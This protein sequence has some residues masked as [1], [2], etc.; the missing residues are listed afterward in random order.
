[1]IQKKGVIGSLIFLVL[2]SLF[3]IDVV[4][5][6]FCNVQGQVL[7]SIY[8]NLSVQC[9]LQRDNGL[10]SLFS[11]TTGN[12]FPETYTSYYRCAMI[13][14]NTSADSVTVYVSNATHEGQ[15]LSYF[16]DSVL[17]QNITLGVIESPVIASITGST[18]SF[19]GQNLTLNVSGTDNLNVTAAWLVL[20]NGSSYVMQ[21][22]ADEQFSYD[23][24]IPI[25]NLTAITYYVILFDQ[26]N[27]NVTS[28]TFVISIVDSFVPT[29]VITTNTTSVGQGVS[30]LFNG[31]NSSDNI[32][33]VSYLW[34]FNDSTTNNESVVEHTFTSLGTFVVSLTVTDANS[35]SHSTAQNITV[36]DLTPPTILSTHPEGGNISVGRKDVVRVQFSRA[37]DTS[38]I[39]SSS[40]IVT[41]ISQTLVSGKYTYDADLNESIF[42]P[43]VKLASNQTYTVNLTTAIKST[44]G[45]A[46]TASY[47][48]NF[49][50]KVD[51]LDEDGKADYNDTDDDGDEILDVV[52]K[53][54][55][56]PLD[57]DT[58]VTNISIKINDQTNLSQ[59]FTGVLGVG[60]YA[61]A[62]SL[63]TFN[64]DFDNHILDLTN[65]T[66]MD[67]SEPSKAQ[68]FIYGLELFGITK[69][70][71]LSNKSNDFNGVCVKDKELVSIS[72]ITSTC[73]AADEFKVKCDGTVNASYSCT[74][75][76][77]TNQY[78]IT[79]LQHSGVQQISITDAPKPAPKPAT[80]PATETT[81]QVAG[82]AGGGGGGG[83]GS[84]SAS[85]SVGTSVALGA[86]QFSYQCGSTQQCV[87]GQCVEIDCPNGDILFNK[88]VPYECTED[89]VCGEKF[90]H[91]H[92]CVSCIAND[93]CDAGQYCVQGECHVRETTIE[94]KQN[95]IVKM[96]K[97]LIKDGEGT[98]QLLDSVTQEPVVNAE[99]TIVYVSGLTQKFFSDDQGMVSFLVKEDGEISYKI[100]KIGYPLVEG[101]LDKSSFKKRSFLPAFM[102]LVVMILAASY[103]MTHTHFKKK[104]L[105]QAFDLKHFF[106][107]K[108]PEKTNKR[109]SVKDTFEVDPNEPLHVEEDQ[110]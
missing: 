75:Q 37:I 79:G 14:G 108:E 81:T 54:R 31:S 36:L 29:A 7:T 53:I 42:D 69:A 91:N 23:L 70:V 89:S 41:D 80:P 5:F 32:G 84:S 72:E 38:T 18:T 57:I 77:T 88:C 27:L 56:S 4:G 92:K 39:L 40:F 2:I 26:G 55:G 35:N 94:Q 43:H 15:A 58:N 46:L 65:L 99:V 28:D 90:C 19:T 104:Q 102:V 64:F 93:D 8:E 100:Q 10:T 97:P 13:C 30:V 20:T 106:Q 16:S 68:I 22:Y 63:A 59:N 86:C 48:F 45:I 50:V 51:D 98:I 73:T 61:N 1:M 107:S 87:E 17:Y 25:S 95:I 67:S 11:T 105:A 24:L 9:S 52:D 47:G 110:K 60:I 62:D 85:G 44:N 96:V 101:A 76:S 74:Y 3:A 21:E 66:F 49:T 78:R 103:F 33:I 109:I 71:Y 12:G 82:A 6:S 34:D 83:G